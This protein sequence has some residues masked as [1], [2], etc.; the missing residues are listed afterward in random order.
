VRRTAAL[1]LILLSVTACQL[2]EGSKRAAS[3]AVLTFVLESAIDL[4][5]RTVLTQ[6]SSRPVLQST[7]AKKPATTTCSRQKPVAPKTRVLIARCPIA[8]V[9][10]RP[11]PT[12]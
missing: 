3:R 12:S 10:P 11:F 9:T 1:L 2:P 6:S 8:N 5:G 7:P 4:Q